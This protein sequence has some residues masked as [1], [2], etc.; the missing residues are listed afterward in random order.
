MLADV[1]LDLQR[2]SDGRRARS[3]DELHDVLRRVGD[4]SA[5]ELDLRCEE[6]GHEV[7][8]AEL[9]A[10]KRAIE[11]NVAGEA[12][13][14]AADD[15]ARYRDALGCALPLGLPG[16]F[17]EPVPRPLEDL[18]GRYARTHGPFVEREVADRF[19]V[20]EGRVAGVLMALEADGRVVRGEFRPEGVRREWCE[21]DVLRQLRRRSLATLRREVEPVEAEALARFLPAWHGIPAAAARGRRR[22]RGARRARRRADRGVDAR[23]RR[24]AGAGRRLPAVAARRAVHVR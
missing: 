20:P 16:A 14:A 2:L 12:R 7:W 11:V 6:S 24:A 9:L 23:G 21:A 8:L 13:W 3:A 4:L 17:T 19:G 15:A 5:A 18:I 10:E 1:E 22:R